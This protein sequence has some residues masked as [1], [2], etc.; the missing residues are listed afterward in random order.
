MS[1]EFERTNTIIELMHTAGVSEIN[2]YVDL[3]GDSG[4]ITN[5][6]A[7]RIK[8]PN[9]IC[10]DI[11]ICSEEHKNIRYLKIDEDKSI[12]DLPDA[13]VDLFTALVSFHHLK[14]PNKIIE[15]I[16][17][18]SHPETEHTKGTLLI[19]REHDA[20]AEDQPYLDFVHLIEI[21][22]RYGEKSLEFISKFHVGYFSR[23]GLRQSLEN[24]GWK[25]ISS[26]DYPSGISNPQ[27]L[28]SS[29]FTYIGNGK[30]WLTPQINTTEYTLNN[31]TL[32]KILD[33]VHNT[34]YF[35]VLKKNNIFGK[36]ATSLLRIRELHTFIKEFKK[37]KI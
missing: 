20:T 26:S 27:K 37:L 29:I 10:A 5:E 32:L 19:L 31:G 36:S 34:N 28:Y 11:N 9:A 8:I 21:I 22:K 2:T 17:R 14:N 6:L 16:N 33:K 23:L 30:A 15:E 24:A 4:A 18:L 35:K 13:T 7:T 1:R 12:I 25:Y 3:G